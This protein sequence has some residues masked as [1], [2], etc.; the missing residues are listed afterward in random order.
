[1]DW[2]FYTTHASVYDYIVANP[3]DIYENLTCCGCP[4]KDAIILSRKVQRAKQ[5]LTVNDWYVIKKYCG[6]QYADMVSGIEHLYYRSQCMEN[7]IVTTQMIHYINEDYTI[8]K[9]AYDHISNKL[10]ICV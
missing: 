2:F 8:F 7:A 1:M 3:E 9:E 4:E 10:G 6:S 5:K